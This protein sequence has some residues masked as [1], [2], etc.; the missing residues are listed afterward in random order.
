MIEANK[1]PRSPAGP[2]QATRAAAWVSRRNA[3]SVSWAFLPHRWPAGRRDGRPLSIHRY[4]G[5]G[6]FPL[7]TIMSTPLCLSAAGNWPPAFEQ[8]TAP[9]SGDLVVTM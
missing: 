3:S 6:A 9:V 4:T 7:N 2:M 8:V 5:S 1:T